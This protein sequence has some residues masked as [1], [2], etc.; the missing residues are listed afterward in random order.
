MTCG[1]SVQAAECKRLLGFV[2]RFGIHSGG[3]GAGRDVVEVKMVQAGRAALR[4]QGQVHSVLAEQGVHLPVSDL[5]GV[6]GVKLLEELGWTLRSSPTSVV[7]HAAGWG[8]ACRHGFGPALVLIFFVG[9]RRGGPLGAVTRGVVRADQA[10]SAAG[11][12]VD[13]GAR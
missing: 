3:H 7:I 11:A 2:T 13:P 12:A 10:G 5:F 6:A 4:A 9:Y 8:T 1:D